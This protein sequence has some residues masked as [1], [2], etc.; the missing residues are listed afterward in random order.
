MKFRYALWSV[1]VLA[2]C[3]LPF[4]LLGLVQAGLLKDC[5]FL[6]L[7]ITA[8]DSYARGNSTTIFGSAGLPALSFSEH[9]LTWAACCTIAWYG[10]NAAPKRPLSHP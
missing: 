8:M 10:F 2:V 6:G 9:S 3:A 4:L 5:N 1:A 7:S